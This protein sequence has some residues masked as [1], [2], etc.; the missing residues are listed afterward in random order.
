MDDE[1]TDRTGGTPGRWV[2]LPVA[3]GIAA[4]VIALWAVSVF[5]HEAG[6]Q[7][8]ARFFKYAKDNWGPE[9]RSRAEQAI[10]TVALALAALAALGTGVAI[11][12]S[13][14][15]R[16]ALPELAW[17]W[18]A[19]FLFALAANR[20]L[21]CLQSEDVHFAQYGFVAF[22]LALAT[23]R[24][25]LAFV[26]TTLLGFVDEAHQWW[27]MYFHDTYNHLDWSDVFLNLCGASMG[28]L[29]ATSLLR[30]RRHAEGRADEV[31]RGS[32]VPGALGLAALA[33]LLGTILTRTEI[34]HY[35]EWPFWTELDNKKPFHTF[36]AREGIPAILGAGALLYYV[37][38]ERRRAIP[39]P[40]LLAFLLA[41]H[42]A[43]KPVGFGAG[44]PVHESGVP[45]LEV[46]RARGPVAIDGTLDPEEWKGAA[47]V[48]LRSFAPRATDEQR[49]QQAS[50]FGPEL[51]TTARLL[52]D[53]AALYVA[54]EC[55]SEDVWTGAVGRDDPSIAQ[56]PCVEVFLDP[57]AAERTYYEFEVSAGNAVQ[58]LF[59]YWP[60]SPSWAP[61][62]SGNRAPAFVGL[63]RWDARAFKSAVS[64]QGGACEVGYRGEARKAPPTRGY[65]VELAIPW[66]DL[67]GRA[68]WDPVKM[69]PCPPAPGARLRGNLFRVEP[70]R[71]PGAAPQDTY[72]TWSPV[73]APINFHRPQFFGVLE[74]AGP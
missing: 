72:M 32:L 59:V 58:D 64:V 7:I 65:V 40:A 60:G 1:K 48:E 42:V 50:T 74:L 3:V 29:P 12:R 61:D 66:E 37:V 22:V 55:A 52:W 71:A 21:V 69:A 49:A 53:D 9:G 18:V 68:L 2:P 44:Q 19:A 73:H 14:A 56:L 28:A 62:P 51:G 57:D 46:P 4:A 13:K 25:R 38:D 23:G 39:Y 31:E 5:K 20:F 6:G 8:F 70:R 24:P 43:V 17:R 47:R 41:V 54:F 45:T 26:A 67:R 33:A 35:P 27:F 34:G 11:L 15:G 16:A 63:N 10:K 30:I 36:N